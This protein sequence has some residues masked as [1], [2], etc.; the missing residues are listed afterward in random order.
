MNSVHNSREN[1]L[2]V[3]GMT[4]LKRDNSATAILNSVIKPILSLLIL[5]VFVFG[6]FGQKNYNVLF[7][8]VDDLRPAIGAYGDDFAQT[9]TLD[10]FANTAQVFNSAYSNQAVC[11]ASRYNLLLGTRSTTTGLYDFGR[12]FRDYYPDAV[13]MPEY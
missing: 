1:G 9:P 11:V 3:Q 7:I 12:E 10:R 13:T 2:S 8:A 4:S 6:A 5:N